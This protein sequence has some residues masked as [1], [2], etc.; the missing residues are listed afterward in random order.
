MHG[1]NLADQQHSCTQCIQPL[2]S[3]Q[4]STHASTHAC[5]STLE[6]SLAAR[7]IAQ[8]VCVRDCSMA[9]TL[10][11][12]RPDVAYCSF[13]TRTLHC[14]GRVR[15]SSAALLLPCWPLIRPLHHPGQ[16]TPSSHHLWPAGRSPCSGAGPAGTCKA[17]GG[18]GGE[19]ERYG[20]RVESTAMQ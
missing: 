11:Q 12:A 9:A 10:I 2:R 15:R 5:I 7:F 6:S 8:A 4:G 20:R 16:S 14:P 18:G 19:C 1:C 17:S 13:A 3:G